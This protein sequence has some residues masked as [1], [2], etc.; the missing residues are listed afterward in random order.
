M[1]ALTIK[2]PYASLIAGNKKLI[3]IR[4]WKINYRG[5]LYIHAGKSTDKKYLM[6]YKDVIDINSLPLGKIIA[7]CELVDCILL[8][9]KYINNNNKINKEKGYYL[10]KNCIG[11]YGWILTN[12]KKI[13]PITTNGKL[14]LWDYK[15]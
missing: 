11:Y 14:G 8:D 7:E 4:S 3:E 13:D 12:I 10:R 5:K 2:Q 6:E 9:E 1:K 15:G